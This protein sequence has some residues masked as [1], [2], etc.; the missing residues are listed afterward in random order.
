MNDKNMKLNPLTGMEADLL[1]IH[2]EWKID[3]GILLRFK[4]DELRTIIRARMKYL[5]E[6]AKLEGK[7][8][9]LKAKMFEEMAGATGR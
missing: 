6:A 5:A 8:M 2:P 9:E 1:H 3:P 4:D 7:M